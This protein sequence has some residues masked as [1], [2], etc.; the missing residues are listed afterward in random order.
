L[1][2]LLPPLLSLQQLPRS[3]ERQFHSL[4]HALLDPSSSPSPFTVLSS[5][6]FP[7]TSRLS[8][9]RNLALPTVLK[10]TR[11]QSVRPIVVCDYPGLSLTLLFPPLFSFP[12]RLPP[13]SCS[14]CGKATTDACGPCRRAGNTLYFCGRDCQK[15]VRDPLFFL[16]PFPSQINAF[17]LTIPSHPF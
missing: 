8:S 3:C 4:G 15:S 9:F 14:V 13:M 5:P 10:R 16:L 7:P 11:G 12:T 1:R 6:F 17:A 2:L